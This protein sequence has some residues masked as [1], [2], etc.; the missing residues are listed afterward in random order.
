MLPAAENR[1]GDLPF[2]WG[3]SCNHS[4]AS[5]VYQPKPLKKANLSS[6]PDGAETKQTHNEFNVS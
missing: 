5:H 6:S 4:A 2:Q 1:L 3:K